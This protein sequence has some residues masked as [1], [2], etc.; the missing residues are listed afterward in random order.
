MLSNAPKCPAPSSFFF[1]ESKVRWAGHITRM[2]VNR[3]SKE[4][5]FSELCQTVGG[6][7]KHLRGSLK[8]SLKDL[9]IDTHCSET[10]ALDHTSWQNKHNNGAHETEIHRTAGAQRKRAVRKTRATS[11]TITPVHHHRLTSV[12][13]VDEPPV[14]GLDY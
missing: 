11:N 7:S 5:F 8:A 9:S 3:L 4:L 13:H 14:P 6:Q 12:L 10:H 2:P 1:S